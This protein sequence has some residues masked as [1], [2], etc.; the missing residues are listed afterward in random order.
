M[1]TYVTIMATY[2]T[3]MA[4]YVTIMATFSLSCVPIINTRS[5]KSP[6]GK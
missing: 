6:N 3:I 2:V 4:T 5:P 1:I